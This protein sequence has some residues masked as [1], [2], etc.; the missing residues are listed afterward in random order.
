MVSAVPVRHSDDNDTAVARDRVEH[1]QE[2]GNDSSLLVAMR[3]G[4]RVAF[5]AQ[6]VDLV[7]EH[8]AVIPGKVG[9]RVLFSGKLLEAASGSFTF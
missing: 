8:D 7:D 6:G 9:K 1:R 5:W 3:G 2:R 4:A